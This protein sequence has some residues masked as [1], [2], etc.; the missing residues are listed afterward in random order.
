MFQGIG[1][2]KF[3]EGAGVAFGHAHGGWSDASFDQGVELEG[4]GGGF[5]AQ[6]LIEWDVLA[7]TSLAVKDGTGRDGNGEHFLQT[8]GLGAEL[9]RVRTVGFGATAFVFDGENG[10]VGVKLD[11]V[12][13]TGEAEGERAEMKAARG[14]H[15]GAGFV[16]GF[17]GFFVKHATLGGEEVFR[18]DLLNVD[19][20]ALA[21]T[22]AQVLQSRDGEE[23]VLEVG[24]GSEQGAGNRGQGQVT[25]NR[26]Q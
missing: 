22:E 7:P 17:V 21:W 5:V 6:G 18:P 11:D 26:G 3:E 24:H 8:K 10:S 12:G 23:V 16:F 4:G 2:A 19:E 1:Q 20:G 13:D 9:K 25:G 15:A 14:A